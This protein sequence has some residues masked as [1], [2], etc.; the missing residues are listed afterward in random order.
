MLPG[1]TVMKA[2]MF[3]VIG[4][5]ILSTSGCIS[6]YTYTIIDG[7]A[8]ITAFSAGNT[9]LLV[10]TNRL[11][12]CTVAD[13]G[14]GAF[15]WYSGLTSVTIPDTVTSIGDGAFTDCTSLTSVTIGSSVTSIG[16]WAFS[17]CTNLTSV[18]I[19]NSVTAIGYTAFLGCTNLPPSISAKRPL[20]R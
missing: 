2:G 5:I 13:I 9:G 17:D 19:P 1:R 7:K 6:P 16:S 14:K 20:R 4:F 10:I 18:A 3:V 12:G 11:G 15:S 8:T